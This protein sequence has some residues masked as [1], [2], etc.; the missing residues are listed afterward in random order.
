MATIAMRP[1]W[2]AG[3]MVKKIKGK[4]AFLLK[5]IRENHADFS[6]NDEVLVPRKAIIVT[7]GANV[8]MPVGSMS[9]KVSDII[10]VVT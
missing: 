1:G 7:E 4:D 9:F 2:C 6:V 10:G 8:N 5:I 3:T